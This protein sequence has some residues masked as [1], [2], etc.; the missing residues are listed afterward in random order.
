MANC[1]RILNILWI[2]IICAALLT[3]DWFQFFKHLEPCS[4]CL[5][6][7]VAMVGIGMSALMNLRYGIKIEHYALSILFATLGMMFAFR[8]SPFGGYIL[9]YNLSSWS[10]MV[11]IGS[12]IGVALLLILN[13]MSKIK[14]D[15]PHWGWIEKSFFALLTILVLANII[16]V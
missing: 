7:R 3:A 9:G 10:A 2:L 16:P 8:L 4:Y 15:M 5:F 12:I 13:S 11:F 6:Q 14:D 1:Q